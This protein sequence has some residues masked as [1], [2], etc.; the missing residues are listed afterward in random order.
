[1]LPTEGGEHLIKIFNK[2]AIRRGVK[3]QKYKKKAEDAKKIG[4]F[5]CDADKHFCRS[6]SGGEKCTRLQPEA[7]F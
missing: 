2:N 3:A 4:N 6:G 7:T 5:R 1:M